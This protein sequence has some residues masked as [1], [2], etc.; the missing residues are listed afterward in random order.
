MSAMN[1]YATHAALQPK[2]HNTTINNETQ[3][4]YSWAINGAICFCI[5]SVFAGALM[6]IHFAA[7]W[8]G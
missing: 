8:L 5:L 2:P 4:K 7:K 3:E 6:A 1:V